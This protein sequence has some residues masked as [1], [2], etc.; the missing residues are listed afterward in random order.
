MN[1]ETWLRELARVAREEQE[2]EKVRLDERWDRLS[3]GELSAEEEAELQALAAES[4]EGRQ[5]YEA[6]RPLGPEF[7][8]RVVQA[9][10]AGAAPAAAPNPAPAPAAGK[11]G[12]RRILPFPRWH[13]PR[14]AGWWAAAA[15]AA[16]ATLILLLRIFAGSPALPVYAALE[17]N[18]GIQE[19]RGEPARELP[20]FAPGSLLELTLRPETAA[21]GKIAVRG[22]LE[23]GGELRTWE[24]PDPEVSE[25]G[26]VRIAG[27]VGREIEIEPGDWTVWLV[28]GRPR[29]L[30]DAAELQAHLARN[31]SQTRDWTARSTRLRVRREAG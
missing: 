3:A 24:L 18:E 26:V 30:P 12:A 22:F 10:R 2:A 14:L 19:T 15:S 4:E 11:S 29:K 31:R 1:D 28:V 16:A 25:G 13:S 6:F 20:V 27:T 9:L 7:Q 21:K 23:G 8:A 5:A 17:L